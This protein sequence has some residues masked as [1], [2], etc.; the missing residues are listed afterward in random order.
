[1]S[2][3]WRQGGWPKV[4]CSV[5][6]Q[7]ALWGP[8]G[9]GT[10]Q[11]RSLPPGPGTLSLEPWSWVLPLVDQSSCCGPPPFSAGGLSGS[12]GKD[13]RNLI[14]CLLWILV[15]LCD[16]GWLELEPKNWVAPFSV[17]TVCSHNKW[18][19]P[20]KSSKET[21]STNRTNTYCYHHPSLESR[22]KSSLWLSSEYPKRSSH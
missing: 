13:R 16:L 5:E 7:F 10:V 1:M 18:V 17:F 11:W 2:T 14:V 6:H 3:T 19:Y 21:V 20:S 8:L 4:S 12:E 15:R 9:W 22:F